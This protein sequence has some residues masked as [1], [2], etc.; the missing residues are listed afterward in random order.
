LTAALALDYF[1]RSGVDIAIVETGLGGRLDASNVLKPL[2]TITTDISQDHVEILGESLEEI[3]GEKAGIIKPSVPHLVGVLPPRAERVIRKVCRDRGAPLFRLRRNDFTAYPGSGRLDFRSDRFVIE[4]VKPTLKGP[5]QLVN[6]ALALKALEVL[7]ERYRRSIG[8]KTIRYGFSSIVWPG[9]FQVIQ[10][11]DKPTLV[12]DVCHNIGSVAAFAESFVGRF[13]GRKGRMIIGLVKRKPHQAMLDVLSPIAE[14]HYLVP[15]NT[16]RSI[17][18]REIIETLN[19]RSVPVR[20]FGSLRAAYNK[21]S[22]S[23]GP[24]DII[25]IIGSHFLVGEFLKMNGWQ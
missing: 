5:H 7:R 11:P 4:N 19:W 9:R 2:L 6:A 24:D 13:P 20:R 22:K 18:M 3:A 15:L 17:D 8:R 16:K 1:A 23:S 14:S 10:R 21:L 12:L 25:C